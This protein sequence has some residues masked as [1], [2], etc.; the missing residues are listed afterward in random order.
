M[1]IKDRKHEIVQLRKNAK[2]ILIDLLKRF[3]T[4]S[5]QQRITHKKKREENIGFYLEKVLT[6]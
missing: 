4:G 2:A 5:N 1:Y 6:K 3:M